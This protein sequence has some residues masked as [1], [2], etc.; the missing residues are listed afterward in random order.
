M[1]SLCITT[2]EYPLL[3]QLEESLHSNEDPAQPTGYMDFY[4]LLV[5]SIQ[6]QD[7]LKLTR[8]IYKTEHTM[9]QKNTP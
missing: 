8:K 1:R 3:L 5:Y 7:N 4:R 2:G 9:G 6:Q